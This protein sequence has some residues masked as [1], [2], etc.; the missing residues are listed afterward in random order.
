MNDKQQK[1]YN[2][3]SCKALGN[4]PVQYPECT[5]IELSRLTP[6]GELWSDFWQIVYIG[7]DPN[8]RIIP[9]GQAFLD[10]LITDLKKQPL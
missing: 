3:A 8:P 9:K 2:A 5:E 4:A 1:L 7:H 10:D 6:P